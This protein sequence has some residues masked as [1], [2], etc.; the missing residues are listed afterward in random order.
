MLFGANNTQAASQGES[1]TT[2]S[3]NESGGGSML[4]LLLL[5]LLGAAGVYYF[6]KVRRSPSAAPAYPGMTRNVVGEGDIETVP[7]S[8]GG[9]MSQRQ[10]SSPVSAADQ[11]K[12]K[13]ILADVQTAWS[14]QN[15]D[16]LKHL[17]TPEIVHYFS[18]ILSENVSREVENHV[19][20][21]RVLS[22]EVTEA[23]TEDDTDYATVKFGWTARDYTVS[24][25]KQR[26]EPAYVVEGDDK[27]PT[28]ASEAWTFMRYRGGKWL[29]SAIQQVD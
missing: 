7:G 11:D 20:D 8:R 9:F 1:G 15:L 27:N 10:D 13:E 3:A 19:E 5:M 29:L 28:E 26:G 17:A 23:W 12:F 18:T 14:H 4:M 25:T 6:M 21:L 22:A 16:A 24:L 2:D